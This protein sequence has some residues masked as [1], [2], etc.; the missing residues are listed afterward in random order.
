[1]SIVPNRLCLRKVVF[2]GYQLGFLNK[3]QSFHLT[4][5]RVDLN[6][7]HL[8]Q[9]KEKIFRLSCETPEHVGISL[10]RR[11]GLQVLVVAY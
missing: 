5:C 1:M 4:L 7:T 2:P 11:Y 9:A 3:F 8:F 10:C 6:A